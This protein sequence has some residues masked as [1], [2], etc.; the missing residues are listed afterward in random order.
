VR[1]EKRKSREPS[2]V[3]TRAARFDRQRAPRGERNVG[4]IARPS[5]NL[6]PA[7][8]AADRVDYW[9][10]RQVVPLEDVFL[11]AGPRINPPPQRVWLSAI[12][13]C[14]KAQ[15]DDA[16]A[17]APIP[18]RPLQLT[19]TWL[20]ISVLRPEISDVRSSLSGLASLFSYQARGP[21]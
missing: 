5:S 1:A 21:R 19:Q 15:Y 6:A 13:Q 3:G 12:G 16:L 20:I 11:R 14:L 4:R 2:H 7:V 17:A 10:R 18:R 9:I 8:R